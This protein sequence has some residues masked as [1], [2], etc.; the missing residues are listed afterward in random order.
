MNQPY[1]PRTKVEK[2]NSKPG[3]M[4]Q[5]GA[6]G[7]VISY[8]GPLVAGSILDDGK[9][10]SQDDYGYFVRWEDCPIQVFI[11]GSRLREASH[12]VTH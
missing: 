4:H 6:L 5:D 7:E 12:G 8:L 1:S 9:V 3:D 11:M 2:I 10:I